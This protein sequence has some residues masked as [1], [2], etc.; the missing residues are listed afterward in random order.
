MPN[1]FSKKS[2]I[3]NSKGQNLKAILM[4]ALANSTVQNA[5]AWGEAVAQTYAINDNIVYRHAINNANARAKGVQTI[6]Q[7]QKFNKTNTNSQALQSKRAGGEGYSLSLSLSRLV[8]RSLKPALTPKISKPISK[9]IHAKSLNF[10]KF[11]KFLAKISQ[12]S[13][14]FS[15]NLRILH[16]YG[17]LRRFQRLA[18]TSGRQI[19][20]PRLVMT[21]WAQIHAFILALQ[22]FAMTSKRANSPHLISKGVNLPRLT[23]AKPAITTFHTLSPVFRSVQTDKKF[24]LKEFL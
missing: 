17:L 24:I 23:F 12:N 8:E 15:L 9:K 6:A 20:S 2:E 1:R 7:A 11:F 5:V 4:N 10:A 22:V 3:V 13:Q 18:M 16:F 14:I 19:F 21:A